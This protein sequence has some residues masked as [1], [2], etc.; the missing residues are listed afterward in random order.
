MRTT[1]QAIDEL[2]GLPSG[3]TSKL[4]CKPPMR[5][6]GHLSL[7]LLLGA[8]GLKMTL[9]ED[10]EQTERIRTRL[11]ERRMKTWPRREGGEAEE[12]PWPGGVDFPSE[13]LIR[14]AIELRRQ[15][16]RLRDEL[17]ELRKP[18]APPLRRPVVGN[19][20]ARKPSTARDRSGFK[21]EAVRVLFL[22]DKLWRAFRTCTKVA[23]VPI[24]RALLRCWLDT[25]GMPT[26]KPRQSRQSNSTLG[27][28]CTRSPSNIR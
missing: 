14:E 19:P 4:V 22:F 10:P 1:H 20:K 24:R 9:A 21:K 2:A 23:L 17:A 18:V 7:G 28:A 5:R 6:L 16:A 13:V 12:P 25:A 27:K 8:L 26:A 11:E 3:Y 15:V